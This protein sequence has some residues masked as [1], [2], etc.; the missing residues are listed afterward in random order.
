MAVLRVLISHF[1]KKSHSTKGCNQWRFMVSGALWLFQQT[2]FKGYIHADHI[3]AY[4][5]IP[6]PNGT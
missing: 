1:A 3:P 5:P 2:A 6:S 4:W